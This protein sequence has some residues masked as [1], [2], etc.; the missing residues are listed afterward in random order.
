MTANVAHP[1]L[2]GFE[3]PGAEQ[4]CR[5]YSRKP[6]QW[7]AGEHHRVAA[8]GQISSDSTRNQLEHIA[9][10]LAAGSDLQALYDDIEGSFCLV[11]VDLRTHDLQLVSDFIGVQTC[12]FTVENQVVLLSE[13]LDL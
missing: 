10:A 7:V 6:V 13:S 5:I 3:L 1:P 8:I 11:I 4:A 12:Y 2:D 9:R